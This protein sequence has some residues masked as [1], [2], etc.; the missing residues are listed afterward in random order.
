MVEI[1]RRFP[2]SVILSSR[3]ELQ[4]RTAFS[5]YQK[6]Y[7]GLFRILEVGET[8]TCRAELRRRLLRYYV[9][10]NYQDG[11]SPPHTPP[12]ERTLERI[13]D[14]ISGQIGIFR[15]CLQYQPHHL[16]ASLNDNG[17]GSPINNRDVDK[18]YHLIMHSTADVLT[19]RQEEVRDKV[20]YHLLYVGNHSIDVLAAFWRYSP[21]E[22]HG[23]LDHFYSVIRVPCS[24]RSPLA[25]Y[26]RSFH[27]Y[28]SSKM[29]G[30]EHY[31][32]KESL[33]V[34][35]IKRS[36][37]IAQ[38]HS[39]RQGLPPYVFYTWLKV[40]VQI[41][42]LKLSKSMKRE[43]TNSLLNFK[44]KSWVHKWYFC[45]P[46]DS[47]SDIRYLYRKFRICIATHLSKPSLSQKYAANALSM[48]HA[49]LKASGSEDH[50]YFKRFLFKMFANRRSGVATSNVDQPLQLQVADLPDTSA[51]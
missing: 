34:G 25:F 40:V 13:L 4:F 32:S 8:A 47:R 22:L 29:Q 31:I 50:G 39:G 1:G 5:K 42:D 17:F 11:T 20:F 3:P 6:K 15:K 44:F 51:R 7:P 36:L 26:H 28:L 16:E 19:K 38:R 48:E 45:Q 27:G 35:V 43:I 33:C 9:W 46:E 24:D 37:R 30:E 49:P 23:V 21:R 18:A 10:Y 14:A 12:A 2:V 41:S